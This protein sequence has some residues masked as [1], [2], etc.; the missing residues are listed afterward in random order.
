VK[1]DLAEVIGGLIPEGFD[2]G[3]V[4]DTTLIT[5]CFVILR[6][7]DPTWSQ[8]GLA[9]TGSPGMRDESMKLGVLVNVTDRVRTLAGREWDR[10]E[11]GDDDD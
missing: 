10:S 7:S 9:Y 2:L 3:D 5:D 4:D 8:P 1:V 6:L 11:E